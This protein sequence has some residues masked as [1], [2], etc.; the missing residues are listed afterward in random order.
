MVR[1]V[2]AVDPDMTQD[3]V[4]TVYFFPG[5]SRCTD[6]SGHDCSMP[7]P[8]YGDLA[9]L[10][11]GEDGERTLRVGEAGYFT[12]DDGIGHIRLKLR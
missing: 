1:E 9:V 3:G 7:R 8:G 12:G 5:I 4:T 2:Y 11:S 10:H 6:E